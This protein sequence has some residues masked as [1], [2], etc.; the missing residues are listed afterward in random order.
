MEEW[1]GK[2]IIFPTNL[3]FTIENRDTILYPTSDTTKYKIINYVDSIGCLS[4]KLQ[5]LEWLDFIAEIDSISQKNVSFYFYFHPKQR[6][7]LIGILE[8]EEFVYPICIDDN[9]EINRINQFP[10]NKKFRTFLLNNEN[11]IIL[12]GN[13]M[14]SPQIKEL[15]VKTIIHER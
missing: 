12:I 8:Q 9:D 1:N 2:E 15:Y 6:K 7:E 14:H 5:L 11:R 3:P 13:P 10:K 4:C